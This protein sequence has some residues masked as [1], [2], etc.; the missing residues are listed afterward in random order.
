ML[1]CEQPGD[2]CWQNRPRLGQLHPQ[3]WLIGL[4]FDNVPGVLGQNSSHMQERTNGHGSV[5]PWA[6]ESQG[7]VSQKPSRDSGLSCKAALFYGHHLVW[8]QFWQT[9]QNDTLS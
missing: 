4:W 7:Q 3:L 5:C 9:T 6:S 1:K 2:L 8:L